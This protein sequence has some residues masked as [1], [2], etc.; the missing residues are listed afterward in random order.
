MDRR[1]LIFLLSLVLVG[2]IT[3]YQNY[4]KSKKLSRLGTQTRTAF[5][6]WRTQIIGNETPGRGP[7]PGLMKGDDVYRVYNYPNPPIMGLILW[8]LVALP[9]T[10]GS[11]I[12]FALKLIMS[13]FIII[14]AVRLC[15]ESIGDKP[16]SP[17][18]WI[19]VTLCS[20]HPILGDLAHGN[21]NI[22]IAFLV[23]GVLELFRR[24][25]FASAG[26][27]LALAI[28]CKIT[29]AL[30]LPYFGWKWTIALWDAHKGRIAWSRAL[31]GGP[32][33]LL[34][35]CVVGLGIWLFAVP[36][37]ILGWEHNKTLLTSWYEMMA[38]P[39]LI[40]GKI[41]SEHANQSIPG[42]VARLLTNSP[43][44]IAFDDD[45]QPYTAA[46]HNFVDIGPEAARWVVRGFQALWVLAIVGLCWS[47][48]RQGLLTAAEVGLVMLGM[49]LFSER[50]WKH[51]A[52]VLAVPFA[53]L[54]TFLANRW[55]EQK[56]RRIAIIW[57]AI[58]LGLMF[59]PS[60][61]GGKFQDLALTYGT[62]AAAFVLLAIAMCGVLWN[63]L[64]T[65]PRRTEFAP[66]LRHGEAEE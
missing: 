58:V 31:T 28:A 47:R 33:R 66:P 49:L 16:A 37:A 18:L 62:H 41:T 19:G 21:V 60:I 57:L 15:Q 59:I 36:G 17:W 32:P 34:L 53:V 55:H 56:W 5:L 65:S 22:F 39:F 1:W 7:M 30:F 2:G 13:A 23:L 27:T 14:W 24:A 6:R 42:V 52:V 43:S 20:L 51:H 64:K 26:L 10:I 29:P 54:V 50:T 35:A 3:A 9:A 48:Q 8:P 25:W 61:F 38:K 40:D 4:E 44:D 63:S 45:D 11:M 12:W 46:S